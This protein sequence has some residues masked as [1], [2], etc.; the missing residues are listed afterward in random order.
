[1]GVQKVLDRYPYLKHI[2][3]LWP[4]YWVKKMK[5]TNEVVGDNSCLDKSRGGGR[6]VWNFSK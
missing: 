4:G 5:K 3:Q 6:L 2:I 1:M